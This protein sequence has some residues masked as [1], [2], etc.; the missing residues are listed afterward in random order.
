M[1]KTNKGLVI[2]LIGAVLLAG[3]ATVDPTQDGGQ[4]VSQAWLRNEPVPLLH[5]E[6]GKALTTPIAYR[7]QR[8]ALDQVLQGRAPDG[9]KA[10]LTSLASQQIY[11]ANEPIA[12]ILL[13]GSGIKRSEDGYHVNLREYRQPVA[14]VEI[15]YRVAETIRSPLPDVK[16]LRAVIA[17][18]LPI[19]ELPDLAH[20]GSDKFQPLDLIATN[21]G[22]KHYIAGSSRASSVTDPNALA[23][24]LYRDGEALTQ[25]TAFDVV[26]DQWQTLLWLVNRTIANGWAIE[27]GQVLITGT[28]GKAVPLERGLY[29]ADYGRFGRVEWWVD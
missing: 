27:P 12:A 14:E 15:G 23:I 1:V 13:P 4:R 28:L 18:V 17:E 25:G 11:G 16:A 3:C 2:G 29:V 9:Y 5:S 20:S 6:Y 22:A 26:G 19:I 10:G 7:I 24:T 8:Q 21:A